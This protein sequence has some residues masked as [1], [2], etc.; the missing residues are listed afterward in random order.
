MKRTAFVALLLAFAGIGCAKKRPLAQTQPGEV[1]GLVEISPLLR[2]KLRDR[3]H[4]ADTGYCLQAVRLTPNSAPV[5]QLS[6]GL[7]SKNGPAESPL[8]T[9]SI[10]GNPAGALSD[11]VPG[12]L[13]LA[14]T[15]TTPTEKTPVGLVESFTRTDA[16]GKTT[17]GYT[18]TE[19]CTGFS[20]FDLST[21]CSVVADKKGAAKS[22]RFQE[23]STVSLHTLRMGLVNLKNAEFIENELIR[24]ERE[25]FQLIE[26]A[27]Q[28]HAKVDDFAKA[29]GAIDVALILLE[30]R[31]DTL[32]GLITKLNERDSAELTPVDNRLKALQSRADALTGETLKLRLDALESRF[33]EL[34]DT[35][36]KTFAAE[37]MEKL[38]D[39]ERR[40]AALKSV[41]DDLLSR[42][43][44]L[45]L[46][47]LSARVTPLKAKVDYLLAKETSDRLA[48]LE[49]RVADVT[50]KLAALEVPERLEKLTDLQ[51][52]VKATEAIVLRLLDKKNTDAADAFQIKVNEIDAKV[53]GLL[54]EATKKAL[55]ELL[56]KL[57]TA[58]DGVKALAPEIDQEAA[59]LAQERQ[60][61]TDLNREV[62]EL[63]QGPLSGE[64]TR[65]E[66][67][68]ESLNAGIDEFSK[69]QLEALMK[70]L[71]DTRLDVFGPG[72]FAAADE[73]VVDQVKALRERATKAEAALK[74]ARDRYLDRSFATLEK[75]TEQL[76]GE[77]ATPASNKVFDRLFSSIGQILKHT[78]ALTPAEKERAEAIH[79]KL[80]T[81]FDPFAPAN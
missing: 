33:A 28:A 9:L 77:P 44:S 70:N 13:L 41:I 57:K 18:V 2:Q 12:A 39:T 74:D 38:A 1:D 49:A 50:P 6:S 69:A 24:I 32:N 66:Q 78:D 51:S 67:S 3:F 20:R 14:G 76:L 55:D 45:Q 34:E 37:R 60:K 79:A 4:L 73:T 48:D 40:A 53:S 35:H 52:Q 17:K 62:L 11:E 56:G 10:W 68:V 16:K 63:V 8:A 19:L 65:L 43:T 30:T 64:I 23:N 29:H 25:L 42:R 58:S 26:L 71:Q 47:A 59:K 81:R 7:C 54:S 5:I 72:A 80:W 75:R 46:T 22:F 31:T 27:E 36:K 15:A 61:L 21:Q